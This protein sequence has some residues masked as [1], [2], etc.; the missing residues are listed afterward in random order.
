MNVGPFH[1]LNFLFKKKSIL[2][3]KNI[4]F[5]LNEYKYWLLFICNSNLF[6]PNN[7]FVFVFAQ[8][9]NQIQIELF[10]YTHTHVYILG[11]PRTRNVE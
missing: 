2:S 7:S 11:L 4:I 1:V 3:V 5:L 10:V 6:V 8:C 9:S